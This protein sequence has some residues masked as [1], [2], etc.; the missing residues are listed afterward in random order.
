MLFQIN[1]VSI[2][3]SWHSINKTNNNFQIMEGIL[4]PA[5]PSGVICRK[6]VAPVGNY[7]AQELV[8]QLEKSMN[9]LDS[10][11]KTSSFS[12]SY[13]SF[14]N[15]FE[16]RSNFPEIMFTAL[17]DGNVLFLDTKRF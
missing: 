10:G 17:T 11:D 15:T 13:S 5:T 1:E 3:N 7:R 2:P 14:S 12:A 16:I 4:P 6:L 8:T 9:T